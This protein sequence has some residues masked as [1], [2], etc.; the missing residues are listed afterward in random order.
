VTATFVPWLFYHFILGSY[1]GAI[2]D[3]ITIV[4]NAATLVIMLKEKKK[5]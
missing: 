1:V 5:T 2:F 4:T 3:F